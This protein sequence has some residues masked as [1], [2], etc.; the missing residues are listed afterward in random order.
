VT[1]QGPQQIHRDV[2]MH[3]RDGL[4][5]R[6][7]QRG[8]LLLEALLA[9]LIFSIGILAIV[10]MQGVAVSQSTDAKYR[11]DASL[12]ANEL[13]GQMWVGSRATLQADF[14][15][16]GTAYSAWL[17]QVQATLPGAQANPPV[18]VVDANNVATIDIWWQAPSSDP[19]ATPHH[20]RSVAQI[21]W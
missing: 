10:G 5:K 11:V 18:V 15:T 8:V 13:I 21:R 16:G 1:Q 7:S 9:L 20:F 6:D 3:R 4:I 12:L 17:P 19:N 2:D 14:S